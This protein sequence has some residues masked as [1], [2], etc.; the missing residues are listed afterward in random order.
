M[1]EYPAGAIGSGPAVDVVISNCNYARFLRSSIDSAL[2]QDYPDVRVTVVDD[3]STDDSMAVAR[4]Y[5]ERITLIAKGN[6]GQASAVNAG[7]AVTTGAVVCFLDADDVLC[8]NFASRAVAAL[9]GTAGAAK[10][11]F[12]A[13]IIDSAGLRTGRVEPDA[14][15]ALSSGDLRGATLS[16][17]FDLVW[18][19]S[20]AQVYARWALAQILPV[21]EASYPGVGADWYLTHAVSLLGPVV[22]VDETTIGY[23]LHS[24]NGYLVDDDR[25]DLDQ[26][27]ATIGYG[28]RTRRHL[29]RIAASRGLPV[30]G[31]AVSTSEAAC[32]LVSHRWDPRAH[33]IRGDHRRTWWAFGVRSAARRND[34]P[35]RTRLA[36]VTWFTLAA[37]V[38]TPLVAPLARLFFLPHQR[39]ALTRLASRRVR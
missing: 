27:R 1:S 33:P 28:A 15:L 23:R 6:A 24:D 22:A 4:T 17:P 18:P 9:T 10:V 13:A 19:P 30:A 37:M 14:G 35:L 36:L 5:G 7:F 29:V 16:H 20:S 21:P 8:P 2:G 39:G 31:S 3:G 26:I 12:R 34:L 32:C 25:L 38:P 11:V